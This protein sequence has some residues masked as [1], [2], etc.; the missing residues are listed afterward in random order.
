MYIKAPVVYL[1]YVG[2]TG[3]IKWVLVPLTEQYVFIY[4]NKHNKQNKIKFIS[5]LKV[6][7][8]DLRKL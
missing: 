8:L 1:K 6:C 5:F 2:I 4:Y 7:V 3:V